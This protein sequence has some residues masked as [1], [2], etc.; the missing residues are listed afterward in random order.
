M[1]RGIRGLEKF[2]AYA[3]ETQTSAARL[4]VV[5][6]NALSLAGAKWRALAIGCGT[7]LLVPLLLGSPRAA[8]PPWLEIEC[9]G[10]PRANPLVGQERIN[11]TT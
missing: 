6:G 4:E 7:S 5:Q 1:V 2:L 11:L 10:L 3:P 9:G 8:G